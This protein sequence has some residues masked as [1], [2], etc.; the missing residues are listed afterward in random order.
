MERTDIMRIFN[1]HFFEM[2]DD[3]LTIFPNSNEILFA[4][5]SFENL[6]KI[7]PTIIIKFWGTNIYLLYKKQIDEGN[8]A[9]F[10]EKDYSNDLEVVPNSNEI[11]R[12]IDNVRHPVSTMS[13]ENQQHTMKYIQN[14]SRLSTLYQ[15]TN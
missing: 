7:N 3:I 2:F 6:K 4:K 14:L 11:I 13:V 15:Q 1:N 10:V 8:I 12:M 5:T 9:F